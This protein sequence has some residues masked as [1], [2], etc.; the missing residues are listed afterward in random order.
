MTRAS[1]KHK[2]SG[3]QVDYR[4]QEVVSNQSHVFCSYIS[5]ELE[6]FHIQPAQSTGKQVG[7]SPHFLWKDVPLLASGRNERVQ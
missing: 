3:K 5:P 1:S 2:K 4:Y 7:F 6:L